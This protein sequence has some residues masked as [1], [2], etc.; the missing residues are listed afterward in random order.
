MQWVHNESQETDTDAVRKHMENDDDSKKLLRE[1]LRKLEVIEI[2]VSGDTSIGIP[3]L[4]KRVDSLE[5]WRNKF[6][7]KVATLAGVA[8]GLTFGTSEGIKAVIELLK[9]KP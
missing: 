4:S 2:C 6:T 9:H 1:I 7:L 5:K 3:G 8:G